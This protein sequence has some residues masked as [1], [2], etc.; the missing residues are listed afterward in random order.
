M[1]DMGGPS[2]GEDSAAEAR[3]GASK[4]R[5]GRRPGV[6]RRPRTE[7]RAR[8]AEAAGALVALYKEGTSGAPQGGEAGVVVLDQYAVYAESGARSHRG[9]IVGSAGTFNG[10]DTRS[11]GRRLR[12]TTAGLRTARSRC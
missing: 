7:F 3:A 6:L 9:E 8:H 2:S 11:P 1:L 4:V 10:A 12:P 5:H